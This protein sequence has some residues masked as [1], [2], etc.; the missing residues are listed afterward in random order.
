MATYAPLVYMYIYISLFEKPDLAYRRHERAR[1]TGRLGQRSD[2]VVRTRPKAEAKG[3]A[4]GNA[5]GGQ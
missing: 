2:Q 5:G 3:D 4:T 1:A